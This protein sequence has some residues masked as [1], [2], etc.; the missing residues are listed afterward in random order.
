MNRNF[1]RKNIFILRLIRRFI[2]MKMKDLQNTQIVTRNF[3]MIQPQK[4]SQKRRSTFPKTAVFVKL[5]GS[6]NFNHQN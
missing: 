6:W 3:G 4:Y 2:S 1:T 5:H